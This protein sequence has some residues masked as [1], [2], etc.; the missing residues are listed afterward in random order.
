MIDTSTKINLKINSKKTKNLFVNIKNSNNF[1][2][3]IQ[4][5]KFLVQTYE[6][7]QSEIKKLKIE[8]LN[9]KLRINFFD[10]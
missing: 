6:Y 2:T 10:V 5:F 4:T 3:D 8:V 9:L 7:N 1:I